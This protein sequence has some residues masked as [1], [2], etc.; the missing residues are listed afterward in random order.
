MH[1]L[2][3]LTL[4]VLLPFIGTSQSL[5]RRVLS[6]GGGIV[7]AGGMSLSMNIGETFT[8]TVTSLGTKL[9]Q[10]FEQSYVSKTTIRL[11]LEG[12]YTTNR[13]MRPVMFYQGVPGATISV[14]DTVTVLLMN[15]ANRTIVE[16]S[17]GILSTTG[18]LTVAFSE[19]TLNG[20]YYLGIR[21]R[22]S[23]ETWSSSPLSFQSLSSYDF[24]TSS[25]S[26][27]GNNLTQVQSG[28]WAV[29]TGDMN[30][31]GY[32]DMFDYSIFETDNIQF[33]YGYYTTD[34]NGDGFVDTFDFPIF[35]LNNF[36]FV[37]SIQP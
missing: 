36:S 29:Y 13:R 18:Y 23:I 26:A 27:T 6:S 32:I 12:Y 9:T 35:E 20:A 4:V 25:A 34:L 10:G 21:H 1:S 28:I 30:Q 5:D 2:R 22:N 14:V 37:Y 16:S 8:P 15:P 19:K 17:E 3:L 24:T 33:A 11:F 7:T 31:D